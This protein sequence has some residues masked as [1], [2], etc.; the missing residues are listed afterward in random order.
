MIILHDPDTLRHEAAEFVGAKLTPAVE[1]PDR[2]RNITEALIASNYKLL[3]LSSTEEDKAQTLEIAHLTHDKQYLHHV[4][5]AHSLWLSAGIVGPQESVLPECFPFP[6]SVTSQPGPRPPK[7]VFARAGYYAFDLSSG[8]MQESWTSIIASAHLAARAVE[9]IHVPHDQVAD[10]IGT[11]IAPPGS[12]AK[13]KTV[14]ALCRPPG[15]H[16]DGRRAGGYCYINNAAVAVSAFR[17]VQSQASGQP[18]SPKIAV[19]DLDFHHGNGTQ[20][21]FYN[22]PD[23]LYVSIHGEDEFPY[24]TGSVDERGGPDADAVGKNVN[25]PL[26][27]GSSFSEYMKLL[28]E[29]LK[30]I[31]KHDP[32]FL[33]ISMGF[34]TFRLDP[35]GNFAIDTEDYAVMARTVRDQLA[36]VP[37]VV[38]LE[39]GYVVEHLGPNFLAFLGGWDSGASLKITR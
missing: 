24:Y 9:M 17:A 22:D 1:S 25:L 15:H 14:I 20:E 30:H 29:G 6:H 33:V 31:V 38:L 36:D 4:S 16:C 12:Q 21:I 23:V 28:T 32:M 19:L 26:R 8:I 2:I 34:D 7:D 10:A 39:G 35:L 3:S 18:V 37:A 11:S 27:T 13:G 5:S